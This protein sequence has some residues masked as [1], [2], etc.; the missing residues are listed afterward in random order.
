MANL[1]KLTG[2]A[3][4]ASYAYRS[5]Q[6]SYGDSDYYT[7]SQGRSLQGRG[8]FHGVCGRGSHACQGGNYWNNNKPQCQVYGRLGHT[9]LKYYYC[10]N[11]YFFI[12]LRSRRSYL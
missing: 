12:L 5:R 4:K 1:T 9:G 11:Q 2:R 8:N 6:F 3:H 7:N 10:Y